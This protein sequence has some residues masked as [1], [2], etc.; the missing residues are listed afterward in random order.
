L[1]SG[2]LNILGGAQYNTIRNQDRDAVV[3][4]AGAVFELLPGL[5]VYALYSETFAPNGR[6]DTTNP[7]SPFLEPEEGTGL[8][9]GLKV[10]LFED[11][12]YGSVS[13]YRIVRTNVEQ[14]LAG[15]IGGNTNIRIPSGE[16]RANGFELDLQYRPTRSF[17]VN[18]A[19]ANTDA[20]ISK[21]NINNDNPDL[22]GN[23][24]SDAVGQKKEGVAKHDVRVWTRYDFP[25]GSFLDGLALGGG[26]TWR[27][28]PIQ[29]FGTFLQRKAVETTDPQR[30][31]LFAS[32]RR[33]LF[34]RPVNL[35]VNWQNATDEVYHDRRGLYVIPSTVIVSCS[36]KL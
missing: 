4:Q 14:I 21:Q 15:V 7:R 6:S 34:D 31:D 5:N 10:R 23:G 3:P 11:K 24:V 35:R 1:F 29:Q 22:D 17:S 8:E 20:Y 12:L 25:K 28:G 27:Q 19:Y 2:R 16:E 13:V 36:V 33:K 30:V 32:Y 9:A 26:F 18:L